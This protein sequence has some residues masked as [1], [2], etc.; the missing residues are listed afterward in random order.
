MFLGEVEERFVNCWE[1]WCNAEEALRDF[2]SK[3]LSFLN[4]TLLILSE[5]VHTCTELH[6]VH[7]WLSLAQSCRGGTG[8]ASAPFPITKGFTLQ[9]DIARDRKGE[10][11]KVERAENHAP[12]RSIVWGWQKLPGIT[13]LSHKSSLRICRTT[14]SEQTRSERIKKQC[15]F[16]KYNQN[17]TECCDSQENRLIT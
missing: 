5:C 12:S 2:I 11:E 15:Q 17:S 6:A 3:R 14:D 4:T 16:V 7:L 8:V 10:N 13:V 1:S 9:N